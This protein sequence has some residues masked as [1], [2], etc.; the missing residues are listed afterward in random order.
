MI[1][2][3][4]DRGI[5][6]GSDSESAM[7]E[8]PILSQHWLYES[9]RS[10]VDRLHGLRLRDDDFISESEERDLLNEIAGIL[11]TQIMQR[12]QNTD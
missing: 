4:A 2:Y 12:H 10:S 8:K 3:G 9:I 7:P 11:P 1:L 5:A 6:S